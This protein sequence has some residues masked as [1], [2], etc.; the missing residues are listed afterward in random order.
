MLSR[1]V[2]CLSRLPRVLFSVFCSPFSG[3][4]SAP[5]LHPRHVCDVPTST[6]RAGRA[7]TQSTRSARRPKRAWR[8]SHATLLESWESSG[9]S[10][11]PSCPIGPICPT[12]KF[13]DVSRSVKREADGREGAINGRLVRKATGVSPQISRILAFS[14][15]HF[16][17][18]VSAQ[19]G[20]PR[21]TPLHKPR[22]FFSCPPPPYPKGPR[23]GPYRLSTR[24]TIGVDPRPL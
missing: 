2:V 17:S 20:V 18:L 8:A 6:Q 23:S 4:Q 15:V 7:C 9:V 1:T 5:S 16:H 12:A 11:C 13:D 10:R 22:F 21:G 3:A 14:R 19:G 24:T